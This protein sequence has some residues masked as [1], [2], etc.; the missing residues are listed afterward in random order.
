MK[1]KELPIFVDTIIEVVDGKKLTSN[2]ESTIYL[3]KCSEVPDEVQERNVSFIDAGMIDGRYGK[4]GKFKEEYRFTI[5]V[6]VF[7]Y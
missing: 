6:K 7:V 2:E 5:V 1:V 3:G 4:V